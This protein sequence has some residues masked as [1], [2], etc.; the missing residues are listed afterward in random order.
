MY[1]VLVWSVVS[2]KHVPIQ[3]VV[4]LVPAVSVVQVE[5]GLSN[6]IN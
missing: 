6:R 1:C 3:T 4:S 5:T 2:Q